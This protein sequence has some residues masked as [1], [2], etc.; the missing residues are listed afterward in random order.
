MKGR[1]YGRATAADALPTVHTQRNLCAAAST[2]RGGPSELLGTGGRRHRAQRPAPPP[3]QAE[4]ESRDLASH[5]RLP[6]AAPA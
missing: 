6:R 3:Q 1:C 2:V 5:G 4:E